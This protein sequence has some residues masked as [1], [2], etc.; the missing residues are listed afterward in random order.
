MS[1]AAAELS[2]LGSAR[3]ALCDALPASSM[4]RSAAQ[5]KLCS[6]FADHM[7]AVRRAALLAVDECQWQFRDRR[8]NCSLPPTSTTAPGD[9]DDQRSTAAVAELL[10]AS[11]T[12]GERLVDG[13]GGVAKA[14]VYDFSLKRACLRF[15]LLAR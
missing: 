11:I 4:S 2:V 8:W 15:L 3:R 1:A 7:P 9:D 10:A 5:N 12:I 13:A 14:L 6:L